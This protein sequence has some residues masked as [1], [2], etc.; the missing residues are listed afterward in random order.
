MKIHLVTCGNLNS[1]QKKLF[2]EYEKRIVFSEII[3]KE[4][5]IK[6]DLEKEIRI[7]KESS[8]ILKFIE[9]QKNSSFD[10][11]ILLDIHGKNYGS[12][13]FANLI[14]RRSLEDSCIKNLFFII[15]GA[16]GVS[17]IIRSFEKIS[18]GLNTWP[19]NLMKIMLIEQIFRAQT[20]I[21][22]KSYHH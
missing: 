16:F 20:I 18:F 17:S 15:G 14:I 2:E 5:N 21:L 9:V 13:D 22:G 10:P 6:G 8:E 4:I 1:Y 7:Q 11:V 12:I 19:H 3:L